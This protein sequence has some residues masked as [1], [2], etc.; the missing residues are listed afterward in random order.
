MSTL[1]NT[2]SGNQGDCEVWVRLENEEH[3]VQ[4]QYE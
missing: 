4:E 2:G 3:S 1:L